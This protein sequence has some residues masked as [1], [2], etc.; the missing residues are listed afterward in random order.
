MAFLSLFILHSKGR[1]SF[2]FFVEVF[3][4]MHGISLFLKKV[5]VPDSFAS[6]K[7]LIW[8]SIEFMRHANGIKH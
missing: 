1:V 3:L 8:R 4:G 7:I 6:G 2:P 5:S